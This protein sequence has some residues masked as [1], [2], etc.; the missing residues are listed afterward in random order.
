MWSDLLHMVLNMG[1]MGGLCSGVLPVCEEREC[2]WQQLIRNIPATSAGSLA[3]SYQVNG[4][5]LQL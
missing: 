4:K 5:N 3:T 1:L 2:E